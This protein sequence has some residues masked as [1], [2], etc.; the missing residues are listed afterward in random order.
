MPENEE[1]I[2]GCGAAERS[3]GGKLKTNQETQLL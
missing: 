2:V 3:D 1:D